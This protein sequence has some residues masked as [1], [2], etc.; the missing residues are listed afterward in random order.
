MSMQGRKRMG[1][2]LFPPF[3]AAPPTVTFCA[4]AGGE[5]LRFLRH[6]MASND[7]FSVNADPF[8]AGAKGLR[9]IHIRVQQRNGR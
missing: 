9:K 2:M 6:Q 5:Q 3:W 8:A 4:P 1:E 7:E